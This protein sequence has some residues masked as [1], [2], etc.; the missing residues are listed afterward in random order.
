MSE[1]GKKPGLQPFPSL[2]AMPKN[3]M[4]RMPQFSPLLPGSGEWFR[5]LVKQG[6]APQPHVLSSRMKFYKSAEIHEFIENPVAWI[7]RNGNASKP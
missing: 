6:K 4:V 7:A 3:I 2:D 1:E 5:G